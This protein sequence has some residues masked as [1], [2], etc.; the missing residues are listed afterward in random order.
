MDKEFMGE[1]RRALE[2]EY[3]VKLNRVLIDRLRAAEAARGKSGDAR[4]TC[5]VE[6]DVSSDGRGGE[7]GLALRSR[8]WSPGTSRL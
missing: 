7:K 6:E 4:K 1:R 3:F 5:D 8:Y 2:E